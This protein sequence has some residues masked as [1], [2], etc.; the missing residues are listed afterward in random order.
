MKDM[1]LWVQS[2]LQWKCHHKIT[3]SKCYKL[4]YVDPLIPCIRS[5]QLALAE[6]Y[7]WSMGWCSVSSKSASIPVLSGVQLDNARVQELE[8]MKQ[9]VPEMRLVFMITVYRDSKAVVRLLRHLYSRNHF[10]IVNVDS[11]S[12]ELSSQLACSINEFGSNVVIANGTGVVYMASSASQIL[13]QSMQWLLRN[14]IAF[15][16]LV[17]CTGSDYPMMPLSTLEKVLSLR[18]PS[19]PSVMNWNHATWEDANSIKF[20][21]THSILARDTVLSERRPPNS[22]M[23][24]RGELWIHALLQ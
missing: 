22:P 11:F 14:A 10:Y 13:V 9:K 16:Y 19:F 3:S 7:A 8:R 12:T 5:L 15:D 24:S 18:S 1:T 17:S 21:S 20:V 2:K 23:E 6:D 4:P